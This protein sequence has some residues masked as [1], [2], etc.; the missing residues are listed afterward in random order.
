VLI[1]E[2]N[3]NGNKLEI[4][5]EQKNNLKSNTYENKNQIFFQRFDNAQRKYTNLRSNT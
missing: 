3:K 4:D 2:I 5:I 1:G